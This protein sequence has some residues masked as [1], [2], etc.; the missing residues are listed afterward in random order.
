MG[1]IYCFVIPVCNKMLGYLVCMHV[2]GEKCSVF[3]FFVGHL[4]SKKT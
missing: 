2:N 4:D 1:Y 3:D